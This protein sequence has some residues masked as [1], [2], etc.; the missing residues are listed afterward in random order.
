MPAPTVV[1]KS[2]ELTDVH[3]LMTVID[4][5]DEVKKRCVAVSGDERA[6]DAWEDSRGNKYDPRDILRRYKMNIRHG[7]A[8]VK[9]VQ[10]SLTNAGRKFALRAEGLQSFSR[11]IRHTLATG[12]YKDI[13]IKNCHPVI[14]VQYCDAKGYA[15]DAIKDYVIHR[16]DKLNDLMTANNMEINKKNKDIVKKVM[17]SAVNGAMKTIPKCI[18]EL[19]VKPDWFVKFYKQCNKVKE[20]IA[21]DPEN[22]DLVKAVVKKQKKDNKNN[23][24]GSVL[25]HTLCR[26]EDEII[27][28][29]NAYCEDNKIP[30]KNIV[31][32]FDGFMI[33]VGL[34]IELGALSKYVKEKTGYDVEFAVKPFDEI[35]DLSGLAPSDSQMKDVTTI[36]HDAEGAFLLLKELQDRLRVS[37]AVVYMKE[38][39]LWITDKMRID[40]LM[41]NECVRMNFARMGA[42]DKVLPYS[43]N[44]NGRENIVKLAMD[45][46]MEREDKHFAE[47]AFQS[48][49]GKLCFKNGVYDFN[50]RS[51]TPWCDNPEVYTNI[52]I[53]RDFP[54]RDDVKIKEVYDKVINTIFNSDGKVK[55]MLNVIS[56]ALSGAVHEKYMSMCMGHRS[57]GKG[58]ITELCSY[59]FG[60]YVGTFLASNLLMD[61]SLDAERQYGFMLALRSCRLLFANEAKRDDSRKDCSYDG[62]LIKSFIGGDKYKGR[63]IYG[64]PVEFRIQ[65][66]M[67]LMFN[68]MP[69]FTPADCLESMAYF[70]FPYK[71]V[72]ADNM[73]DALP[74]YRPADPK[75]KDFIR[76]PAVSDAF[77]HIVLDHYNPTLTISKEV[78]DDKKGVLM[79]CGNE[80]TIF[81]NTFSFARNP[82]NSLNES[83]ALTSAEITQWAKGIK[84]NIS[85]IKIKKIL[86]DMGFMYS[87]GSSKRINGQKVSGYF[88]IKATFK[89]ELEDDD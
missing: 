68:D 77:L 18:E 37:Q 4:N 33:P 59:A 29:C 24:E 45:L 7:N 82:D 46:L 67:F 43:T 6:C 16:D 8:S 57:S 23:V 78:M 66:K 17:L 19:K 28:A 35:I 13:D 38:G 55:S 41:K 85:A 14:L 88:G 42:E 30:V 26:I 81:R 54:E 11:A 60:D 86:T 53:D 76:D 74:F 75:I 39:N 79:D 89:N 87:N 32:C 1:F 40:T 47:K 71:F 63:F 65:G 21:A 80:E 51:F 72:D 27:M 9:Y 5:W 62:N 31:L 83:H 12:V 22:K 44:K 58:V 36:E 52:L 69:V 56:N 3:K 10:S 48:T 73:V 25:N 84:L 50:S 70:D 49:L 15:C 20:Q 2:A 61:N 34:D 64:S